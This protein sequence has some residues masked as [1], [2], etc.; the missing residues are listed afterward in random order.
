MEMDDYVV[1]MHC[2]L[3]RKLGKGKK[4]FAIEGSLVV[5]EDKQFYVK[6]WRRRYNSAK[7]KPKVKKSKKKKAKAEEK[8]QEIVEEK[9]EKVEKKK[10]TARERERAE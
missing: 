7:C 3:G 2:S 6:E 9:V 5:D 10:K 8:K 1:D 4:D